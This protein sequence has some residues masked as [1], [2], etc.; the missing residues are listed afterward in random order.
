MA[1]AGSAAAPASGP[2]ASS[3]RLEPSTPPLAFAA[4]LAATIA[5]AA[6]LVLA[7]EPSLYLQQGLDLPRAV[8]ALAGLGALAGGAFL[9]RPR[10][11]YAFDALSWWLLA[12][13]LVVGSSGAA[14]FLLFARGGPVG[15]LA[16]GLAV[17][18]G[19]SSGASVR[20]TAAALFRTLHQLGAFERL[21]NPFRLGFGAV[22]LGLGASALSH[23]GPLRASILLAMILAALAAQ[24]APLAAYLDRRRVRGGAVARAIALGV[25]ALGVAAFWLSTRALPLVES[26]AYA[27]PV[28][29]R[30]VTER[31]SFVVTSGQDAFELWVDGR[32]KA[33]SVDEKRY[34]QALVQPA[35][36]LA[37]RR[38][39]VLLLAGGT[40]LAEREV[41]RHPDVESLTVVVVDRELVD[42]AR[43][44]TWLRRLSHDALSSPKVHVVQAEPIV[45]LAETKER[46]D[47]AIA[48]LP[49]PEGYL[50]GKSYTRYFF[51]KL[52]ACL[53][54]DGVMAVQAASPFVAPDV[55]A[56]VDATVAAAGFS[57]LPYHAPVPTFG[58]WGFVLAKKRGPID[59]TA[60]AKASAFLDG[61]TVDE[62]LYLPKDLLSREPGQPSRLYD[63]ELVNT[64]R[65]ERGRAGF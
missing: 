31:Q 37:P 8:P 28:I 41:L 58:D 39:R 43:T 53:S 25:F 19:F 64:L 26:E 1:A 13:A 30:H 62:M 24:V 11:S 46:F 14:F 38:T 61:V 45:F 2:A 50:E 5:G 32:I 34:S 18:V 29:W 65:Q 60:I 42:V 17:A 47:V 51:A 49:D 54:D 21:S 55:L 12:L 63:Q 15:V 7:L 48:D 56:G 59:R 35:L 27:N 40:G 20:L 9:A 57:T 44:Q 52:A 36:A 3:A 16:L 33:S 23:I 6:H 10:A 22:A 4:A